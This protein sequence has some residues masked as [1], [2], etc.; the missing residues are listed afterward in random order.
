M[1]LIDI[2]EGYY[3]RL[4][5]LQNVCGLSWPMILV[6]VF[7]AGLAALECPDAQA[8]S[9]LLNELFPLEKDNA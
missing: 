9:E 4:Q 1:P 3:V 7:N 6:L 8:T 5:E 2:P